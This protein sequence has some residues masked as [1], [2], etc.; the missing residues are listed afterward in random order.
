MECPKKRK[1]LGLFNDTGI[2]KIWGCK[3]ERK[4]IGKLHKRKI[5]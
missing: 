5:E 4:R 1:D 3:F 2:G